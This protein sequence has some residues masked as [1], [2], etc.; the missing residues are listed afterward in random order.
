M[1]CLPLSSLRAS[2]EKF[3][4]LLFCI[5]FFFTGTNRPFSGPRTV[6]QAVTICGKGSC[7][8]DNFC[9]QVP[10]RELALSSFHFVFIEYFVHRRVPRRA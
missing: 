7:W 4:N 10:G 3:F 9:Q 5:G 2:S 8:G 6:G 1:L